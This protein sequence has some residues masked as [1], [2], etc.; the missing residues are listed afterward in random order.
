MTRHHATVPFRLALALLGLAMLAGC[1]AIESVNPFS[2]G[3]AAGSAA[4]CPAATILRPLTQTAVFVPGVEHTPTNVAF[5]GIL[6]DVSV[7]CERSGG[8]MHAALDVVVI[9]ARGPSARGGTGVDLQY[10]VAVTGPNDTILSKRSLPVH[11]A[12]AAD[13]KRG[14]VT[15]HID[16]AIPLAGLPAG[17]VGI[18]LGFQLAPDV[19]DFYKHYRGI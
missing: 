7:K 19:I 14:G 15:D 4:A 10:F 11:V 12:I 3:S 1:G 18:V 6:N 2:S 13:A 5:Y 8:A 16:E 9:G 17:Q